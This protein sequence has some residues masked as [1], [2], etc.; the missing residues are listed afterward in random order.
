MPGGRCQKGGT[1][2][3]CAAASAARAPAYTDAHTH[4]SRNTGGPL[5]ERGSCSVPPPLPPPPLLLLLLL[6][7]APR[8]FHSW[9]SGAQSLHLP[10]FATALLRWSPGIKH[11]G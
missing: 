3:L 5:P 9:T 11:M 7:R 1:Q 6:L 8:L 10:R 4:T 2:G